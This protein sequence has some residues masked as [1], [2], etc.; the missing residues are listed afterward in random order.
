[1]NK[2]EVKTI[3]FKIPKKDYEQL[4]DLSRS[5]FKEVNISQI[6]RYCLRECV[7]KYLGKGVGNENERQSNS[8]K[9]NS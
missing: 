7:S 5:I 2:E 8:S 4:I 3:A 9:N 1:M 6:I